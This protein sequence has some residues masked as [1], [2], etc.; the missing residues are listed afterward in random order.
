MTYNSFN[1]VE[2]ILQGQIGIYD[3]EYGIDQQRI[4]TKLIL[5][6]ARY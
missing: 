3:I 5:K 6:P 2:R 4:K 1:K